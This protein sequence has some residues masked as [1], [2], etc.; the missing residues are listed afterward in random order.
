MA[1]NDISSSP[2]LRA[3][4]KVQ[5]RRAVDRTQAVKGNEPTPI[6]QPTTSAQIRARLN[7][8]PDETSLNDMIGKALT[9]L[10][11]GVRWARGSILNLL[12]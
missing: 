12:V 9:A 7:V 4:A 6:I 1:E 5:A 3:A 8:I 2:F 10:S 11:R